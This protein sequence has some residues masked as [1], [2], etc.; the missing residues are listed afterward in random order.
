LIS[1]SYHETYV[2]HFSFA[3]FSDDGDCFTICFHLI[4]SNLFNYFSSYF[5]IK[6]FINFPES[7]R[8]ENHHLEDRGKSADGNMSK[9]RNLKQQLLIEEEKSRNK[10]TKILR[11]VRTVTI[12][13]RAVLSLLDEFI[14]TE[15][16]VLQ[17]GKRGNKHSHEG[18]DQL[19]ERDKILGGTHNNPLLDNNLD[20]SN[21]H[22]EIE[23]EETS[24][25]KRD[26]LPLVK[27]GEWERVNLVNC[28]DKGIGKCKWW[29]KKDKMLLNRIQE[30]ELIICDL[31]VSVGGGDVFEKNGKDKINKNGKKGFPEAKNGGLRVLNFDNEIIFDLENRNGSEGL[32]AVRNGIGSEE[33][34]RERGRDRE[35][36]RITGREREREGSTE[37]TGERGDVYANDKELLLRARRGKY[38]NNNIVEITQDNITEN[39][40]ENIS[41][42]MEK[43]Q[44]IYNPVNIRVRKEIKKISP[45][46]R[47]FDENKDCNTRMLER[48]KRKKNSDITNEESVRTT[49]EEVGEGQGSG[50]GDGVGVGRKGHSSIG[51]DFLFDDLGI[52]EEKAGSEKSVERGRRDRKRSGELFHDNDSNSNNKMN[53]DGV[54]IRSGKKENK[55]KIQSDLDYNSVTMSKAQ[56]SY[57]VDNNNNN[58]STENNNNKINNLNN[59]IINIKNKEHSEDYESENY[60][61]FE[62]NYHEDIL[63]YTVGI[64]TVPAL[65]HIVSGGLGYH[66]IYQAQFPMKKDI[67]VA[68]KLFS[69]PVSLDR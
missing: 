1:L 24:A 48:C 59:N 28:K 16:A 23:D 7:L 52:V 50:G 8:F 11:I 45:E 64:R 49:E 68:V 65:L 58:N 13:E 44:Q 54:R 46:Y 19:F 57:H 34:E 27:V 55:N 17:E 56:H 18:I 15:M 26:A 42:P 31:N 53:F 25:F 32:S 39:Y 62:D 21:I 29:E 35:R 38:K 6:L 47:I 66:P 33:R 3:F 63:Y 9:N 30:L 69:G 36:E 60:N 5:F 20:Q 22:H 51:R 14:A 43:N 4:V 67:L 10:N 12:S 61:E 40:T 37:M 41:M 2:E